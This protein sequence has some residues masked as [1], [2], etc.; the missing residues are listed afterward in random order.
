MIE[1]NKIKLIL[2]DLDGTLINSEH[3]H[4]NAGM[5]AFK[6]LKISL[7]TTAIGDG[8]DSK[9]CFEIFTG[10]ALNCEQNWQIFR[11]WEKLTVQN[12]FN[13]I[14]SEL[15][16]KQSSELVHYFNQL[17]ITQAV[18]SNSNR[19]IIEKSILE[20]NLNKFIN[21]IFSIEDV[22]NPKPHPEPYLNALQYYNCLSQN[23]IVFEDSETGIN[24][25]KKANIKNIFGI[26]AI[27]NNYQPYKS[28]NLDNQSWRADIK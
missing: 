8:V 26:G 10:L 13:S 9:K 6:Q 5:S 21:K 23:A 7:I 24:A 20:L 19:K 15:A 3:I 12:T 2:W 17:G 14:T 4:Y 22:V 1:L 11:D 16:I 28:L 18:V 27:T 25:A